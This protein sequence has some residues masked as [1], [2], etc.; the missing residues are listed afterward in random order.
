MC[1]S[2]PTPNKFGN[3]TLKRLWLYTDII[4]V[5]FGI[6]IIIDIIFSNFYGPLFLHFRIMFNH[7]N[8]PIILLGFFLLLCS[9]CCACLFLFECAKWIG[10]ICKYTLLYAIEYGISPPLL[11]IH[12]FVNLVFD[13]HTSCK[14]VW[15]YKCRQMS[16]TMFYIKDSNEYFDANIKSAL[17]WYQQR[18]YLLYLRLWFYTTINIIFYNRVQDDFD[19]QFGHKYA[20]ENNIQNEYLNLDRKSVV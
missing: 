15:M 9:S 2:V 18:K 20:A 17:N 3:W 16:G 11:L 13:T 12:L 14:R 19:E 8:F 6:I 10:S 4:A 7:T 1:W 5:I